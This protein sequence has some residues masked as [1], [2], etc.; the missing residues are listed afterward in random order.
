MFLKITFLEGKKRKALFR[1]C[2]PLRVWVS[3]SRLKCAPNGDFNATVG[4]AACYAWFIWEKG[5][6]GE[7]IIKWFN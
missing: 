3:S 7:T 2:P 5:Y 1:S 4:S 6:K